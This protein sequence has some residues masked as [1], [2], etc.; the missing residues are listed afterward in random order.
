MIANNITILCV[1]GEEIPRTLRKLILQKKGYKVLTATSGTEAL[2]STRR[3]LCRPLH[4]QSG[5]AGTP[6]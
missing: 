2:D 3:K 5:W 6:V 4:K 1:D